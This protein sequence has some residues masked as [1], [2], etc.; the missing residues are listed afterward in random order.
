M[1]KKKEG[2]GAGFIRHANFR[3]LLFYELKFVVKVVLSVGGARFFTFSR[4]WVHKQETTGLVKSRDFPT[5]FQLLNRNT[6]QSQSPFSS[7]TH[8]PIS[9]TANG[10]A[11]GCNACRPYVYMALALAVVM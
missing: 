8:H 9:A 5:Q 3:I 2:G 1:R 11:P 10:G 7:A 4:R 6:A